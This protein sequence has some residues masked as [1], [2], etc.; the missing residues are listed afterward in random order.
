MKQIKRKK[1]PTRC[2]NCGKIIKPHG[3][4]DCYC[5][6]CRPACNAKD[7]EDIKN[8]TDKSAELLMGAVFN[9]AK[10]DYI[11]DVKKW[12]KAYTEKTKKS[13]FA[14]IEAWCRWWKKG[15]VEITAGIVDGKAAQQSINCEI[16]GR[17]K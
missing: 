17:K 1:K 3:N 14:T 10:D 15:C 16:Y 11:R 13:T 7:V 4:N 2:F 9:M 5:D 6:E 8:I 12:H